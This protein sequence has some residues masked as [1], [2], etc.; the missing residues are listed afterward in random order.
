MKISENILYTLGK[1]KNDFYS[2]LSKLV[3]EKFPEFAER[4]YIYDEK[5]KIYKRSFYSKDWFEKNDDYN[6][7]KYNVEYKLNDV[8]LKCLSIELYIKDKQ[9]E[10]EEE[11]NFWGKKT[12]NEVINWNIK[13]YIYY[14]FLLKFDDLGDDYFPGLYSYI[15]FDELCRL[16]KD[17]L[18]SKKNI[19]IIQQLIE[20]IESY[21]TEY[22]TIL[23]QKNDDI[24]KEI[25]FFDKNNDG[26]IDI[27]ESSKEFSLLISK[28]QQQIIDFDKT[29]IHKF[30]KLSNYLK[31][32]E[33]NLQNIFQKINLK[34]EVIDLKLFDLLKG[35]LYTYNLLFINSISMIN[36]LLEKDYI[37]YYE[38]YET[39][40]KLNIFNSNW[41]NEVSDRLSSI[42]TSLNDLLYSIE[43]MEKNITRE[44]SKLSNITS[45]SFQNLTSTLEKNLISI[46]SSINI[47]NI[48][49]GIQ[50]YQM[51]R[52]NQNTKR[53]S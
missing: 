16:I 35:Q 10:I 23:N 46:N 45:N 11:V 14:P 19:V 20:F 5:K 6:L 15:Q 30:V 27:V 17:E 4:E 1:N 36:S 32:K 33:G 12:Y 28:F 13:R 8:D 9:I 18:S 47:N 48:L 2:K 44:L 26:I 25:L 29:H 51:Y 31:N 41:E 53:I 50:T 21:L 22:D 3:H 38:I 24:K 39:Y 34:N 37:H 7:I 42:N 52:I 49:T 43:N 40:D